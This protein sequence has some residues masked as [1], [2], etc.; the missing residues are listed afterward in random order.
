MTS[1][2]K[3]GWALL[4][5]IS[6]IARLA[7]LGTR[8]MSHDESLHALYSFYWSQGLNYQ[9]DP[10][11]HGPLLFHLNGLL[12]MLFPVTDFT[13]RLLPALMGTGCVA[14]M[15][16]YRRWLGHWG[17]FCA[18]VLISID[19]GHLF[20]SRYIRNDIYISLFTLVMVWALFRF[21]ETK[22]T[23]YLLWLCTGLGLSFACKEVCF[24]HGVMLGAGCGLFSIVDTF[25]DPQRSFSS[26]LRHPLMQCA[27]AIFL[28]ALPFITGLLIQGGTWSPPSAISVELQRKSFRIGINLIA[29]TLVLGATYFMWCKA[30]GAWIL[31]MVI[32]WGIQLT[33]Y[34]TFFTQV[35]TGFAS[36]IAGS[37]G[38]W[39]AQHDVQRGSSDPAYYLTLLLLYSPVLLIGLG[40]SVKRIKEFPVAF[41]LFWAVL[42]L[43]IYSWAGERMP[44]LLIHITL[45]L[46]IITGMILPEIFSKAGWKPRLVQGVMA[47][48]LL[49]LTMNSL[50]LAGPHAEGPWE[51]L[52]YAHSGKDVKM[53]MR[54]VQHHL[55][56]NPLARI[57]VD[58]AYSWPTAWYFRETPAGYESITTPD[59]VST[60]STAIFVSPGKREEFQAAGWTSR[61]EIDLTTWP[62][63]RYHRFTRKNLTNL[64]TNPNIQ[65]KLLRYYLTRDQPQWREGEYPG[66]NRLLLMTREL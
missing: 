26:W 60:D 51:P 59:S 32:F 56:Q 45:P 3:K 23:S 57:Q 24:I 19:P 53:T 14:M 2:E 11:M 37:L 65:K 43:A 39:W 49:Q 29:I 36:G 20:Y 40:I 1:K 7:G 64:F 48:G 42:H 52:V 58:P 34:T 31:S 54:M 28:L 27:V 9:H 66:P 18:A 6:L 61:V 33:L 5:G 44:W 55:N 21:R 63:Q 4:I 41:L 47:I 12:F 62:R 13:A 35:R 17:A 16:A 10:M 46:C 22:R 25:H 30:W 38:Y 8:A 15:L 50:R